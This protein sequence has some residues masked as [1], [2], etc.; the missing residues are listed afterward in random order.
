VNEYIYL[1]E[2]DRSAARALE[3]RGVELVV[4][5]VPASRAQRLGSLDPESAAS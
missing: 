3:A 4:Q 1:D 2:S 5:D